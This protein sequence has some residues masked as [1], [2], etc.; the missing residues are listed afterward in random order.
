MRSNAGRFVA[1]GT[2]SSPDGR[3]STRAPDVSTAKS[4]TAIPSARGF[5][6]V[7]SHTHP[8]RKRRF[9]VRPQALGVGYAD[10]RPAG[11]W[12]LSFLL[13]GGCWALG[14]V[15]GAKHAT[16]GFVFRWMA[17]VWCGVSLWQV[18]L[19]AFGLTAR[20][21]S[22]EPGADSQA[23][24]PAPAAELPSAQNPP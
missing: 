23:P 14:G 7:K 18:I 15:V 19:A 9:R 4:G 12:A 3:S 10:L 2:P 16:V 8:H 11:F 1:S 5:V 24:E 22:K 6:S 20:A 13:A 17:V 21:R